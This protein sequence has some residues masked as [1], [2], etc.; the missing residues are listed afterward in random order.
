MAVMSTTQTGDMVTGGPETP[1]GKGAA[2]ENFPVGSFLLPAK[3]RPHVAAFYAFARA[4]DD[5]ADNPDLAPEDKVARLDAFEAALTGESRE[6]GFEKA[7]RL[8]D[9]LEATGVTD[10]HAR[11]LLSAFRQDA[12]KHRYANWNELMDYC[13]RSANPVGRFLLDLHGEDAETGY[14]PSDTLCTVLQVLN[15]LQDCG[16]DYEA[17]NRVYLPADWRAEE[18]VMAAHLA[19][20]EASAG[21]RAVI[22]RCLDG[23]DALMIEARRLPGRLKSRRLAM[24]SAVIVRLAARLAARLRAGDPLAM[25]VALSRRD[26][27]AAGF[28]GAAEGLFGRRAR[29]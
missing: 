20:P 13:E 15:H 22:D 28:G 24:E 16:K 26:F 29:R 23:V 6:P 1:S 10:R 21:L 25:R 8:R 11:D 9:S 17:L 18:G 7:L 14:G 2:D 5:I 19:A 27:I 3:L 12:V 4:A